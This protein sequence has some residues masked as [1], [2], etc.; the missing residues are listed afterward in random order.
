MPDAQTIIEDV[1]QS[2]ANSLS[3]A[4][5]VYWAADAA[6]AND[7]PERN[8]SLHFAHQLMC[9]DF[10]LYAEA[11]HPEKKINGREVQGID[12]LAISPDRDYYL[13]CEFKN[14]VGHTMHLSQDDLDR[15]ATFDLN[16]NFASEIMLPNR[17][18]TLKKCAEGFGLVAG[19][20]W[21]YGAD[22]KINLSTSQNHKPFEE[23]VKKLDGR[24]LKEIPLN[25]HE[26]KGRY[27]L[28]SALL[29][30]AC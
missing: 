28:L 16:R 21:M 6:G 12:M 1:L 3:K 15:V 17:K 9:R 30:A 22:P 11:N 14:Y 24:V 18:E 27:F 26:A 23:K 7:L 25:K 19:L 13:A 20:T 4:M 10:S 8:L 29:P 2:T 5:D